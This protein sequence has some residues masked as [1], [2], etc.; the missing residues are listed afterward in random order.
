MEFKKI[1]AKAQ[2]LGIEELE[3]YE[4]VNSSLSFSLFDDAIDGREE[5]ETKVYSL[6]GVYNNQIAT[7][8]LENDSDESIV[9]ALENLKE[10]AMV[11]NT[12]DAFYIYGG[13]KDYEELEPRVSDFNQYSTGDKIA[14]LE[15]ITASFKSKTDLFFH[16]QVAYEESTTTVTIINSNGLNLQRTNSNVVIVAELSCKQNDE[17]KDSYD[18]AYLTKLSDLNVEE[19]TSKIV[20]E[21]LDKFGAKTIPS[22]SY[23]VVLQNDVVSSLLSV[24]SHIFLADSVKNKMSFLENKIGVKVFGENVTIVDNPFLKEAPA[25][26][27]FDDEGVACHKHT[28]VD[29]GVLKTYLHNLSTADYFKTKSTGNGYKKGVSGNVAVLPSNLVLEP[30]D[31]SF[32]EILKEVGEGVLITSIGGL[33]A[34]VNPTSGEFNVQSSGYMIRNGKIA[35]A[36]TLIILS[37]KFQDVFNNVILVGNDSKYRGCFCPS[38]YVKNMNISGN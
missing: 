19:F 34:G 25:N 30:G 29:K 8:Y 4:S 22:G 9:K 10:A 11:I 26:S 33:H 13:D 38:I 3:L 35:E 28:L 16:S 1:L 20:K 36:I 21:A 27:S 18:Y 37:G 7:V 12:K 15:S 31:S 14:L 17:I 2:D 6:R 5:S 24:Y 32:S 23:K